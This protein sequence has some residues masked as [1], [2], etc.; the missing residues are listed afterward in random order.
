MNNLNKQ[1]EQLQIKKYKS[2][3]ALFFVMSLI[4]L[5][6]VSND[7]AH[8]LKGTSYQWFGEPYLSSWHLLLAFFTLVSLALLNYAKSIQFDLKKNGI[9]VS[10]WKIITLSPPDQK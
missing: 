4:L 8:N 6:P 2:R 10:I 7:L 3:S 9:N 5:F 1:A